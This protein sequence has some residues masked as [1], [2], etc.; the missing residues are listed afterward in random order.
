VYLLLNESPC[1]GIYL[2]IFFLLNDNGVLKV[3]N[4]N[5][6]DVITLMVNVPVFLHLKTDVLK[7]PRRHRHRHWRRWRQRDENKTKTFP[8]AVSLRG[9]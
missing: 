4:A 8:P 2:Y 9:K 5:I 7:T 1:I 3:L 6:R